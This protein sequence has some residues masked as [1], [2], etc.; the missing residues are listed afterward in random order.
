MVCASRGY[1]Q[2]IQILSVFVIILTWAGCVETARN[3][4]LGSVLKGLANVIDE[5]GKYG[6]IDKTGRFVIESQFDG[7]NSFSEALAVVTIDR[8]K[9]FIDKTGELKI[10]PQYESADGFSH[11]LAM[12]G[13]GYT[14]YENM[15]WGYIDTT[16]KYIWQPS[17]IA[18]E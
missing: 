7:A 4:K 17:Q 12:T 15:K 5:S 1:A 11:G 13:D 18:C 3:H 8:K 9:G 16:G 2:R 14:P 10:L 6:F